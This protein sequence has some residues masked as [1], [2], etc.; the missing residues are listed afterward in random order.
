MLV[1]GGASRQGPSVVPSPL[2]DSEPDPEPES[3]PEL[4]DDVDI[5]ANRHGPVVVSA[6]PPSDPVSVAELVIGATSRHGPVV[7]VPS[8]SPPQP[9]KPRAINNAGGSLFVSMDQSNQRMKPI[10]TRRGPGVKAAARFPRA[11]AI[12]TQE[13][14]SSSVGQHAGCDCGRA[15][16]LG[17]RGMSYS[18]LSIH[19]GYGNVHMNRFRICVK[20]PSDRKLV[21]TI[22]NNL[23]WNMPSY[24]AASSASVKFGDHRWSDQP[25]L[26]FRGVARLRP[27]SVPVQ[28]PLPG[29]IVVPV[30]VPQR[31][32]DW[33][34]PDVH[35]DSVGLVAKHG[36]G[37]TVQTLKRN[38]ENRDDATIRAAILALVT[39]GAVAL[40]PA[41]PAASVLASG[42]GSVAV[43]YNQHHFLAGR[44]GFRFDW[45]MHFG[46]RD[47]RC[48]M[49]TVAIERFSSLVFAGSVVA[50]GDVESLV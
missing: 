39:S 22:G 41:I 35:T 4:S 49:E 43:Y 32:R 31:V 14:R 34:A 33:M 12:A 48:V 17:R 28:I 38:Y 36:T 13:R 6:V 29:G 24:M 37:F 8:S 44:R 42:L 21:A 2:P 19:N 27:F 47:D 25:T 18:P 10:V 5:G 16:S 9:L 20:P 23:L 26:E 7:A 11:S 15:A 40:P 46:Y 45:G 50:M 1:G 30:P 3:E